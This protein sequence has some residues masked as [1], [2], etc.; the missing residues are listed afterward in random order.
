MKGFN[1]FKKIICA[2][3]L[4]ITILSLNLFNIMQSNPRLK[5]GLH[6]MAGDK[7]KFPLTAADVLVKSDLIVFAA[8]LNIPLG[9]SNISIINAKMSSAKPGDVITIENGIYSN[10]MI[11]AEAYGTEK[12]PITLKAE[13]PGGVIL[14][15]N[16]TISINGSY[17]VTDGF[18]FTEGWSARAITFEKNSSNCRLTNTA[19][20]DWNHSVPQTDTRWITIKGHNNRVDHCILRDKRNHGMM[21]EVIRDASAQYHLID[22]NY[23][24]FYADGIASNGA[25]T[26]RIGTSGESLSGSYTVLEYNVFES[27]NGEA[28]VVSNKSCHNIYRYN[29]F[30][31]CKGAL[32]LRHGFGCVVEGNVFIGGSK[33]NRC[34]GVRVIGRDHVVKNNYFYD[35]PNG[36]PAIQLEHGHIVPHVLTGYDQVERVIVDNNTFFQCDKNLIIGTGKNINSDPPRIMPPKGSVSNNLMVSNKGTG[37]LFSIEN[38]EAEIKLCHNV[39]GGKEVGLEPLPTGIAVKDNINMILASNGLYMPDDDMIVAGITDDVNI[40]KRTIL[41]VAP[42]WVINRIQLND[43]KFTD[44]PLAALP[45]AESVSTPW[46]SDDV[47]VLAV[48]N[49]DAYNKNI[50]IKIDPVSEN[51]VPIIVDGKTFMPVR[52]ISEL[53][54]SKVNWDNASNAVKIETSEGRAAKIVI[55]SKEIDINGTKIAMDVAAQLIEERTYLPLRAIVE[56]VLGKKVKWD[57]RGIILISNSQEVIDRFDDSALMKATANFM[58]V[59][60]DSDDGNVATNLVDNDLGTRWSAAGEG[61]WARFDLYEPTLVS[62]MDIATYS[63][64]KRKAIFDIQVSDDGI[65][66]DTVFSGQSSGTA[67]GFERYAFEPVL[68]RYVRLYGYGNSSN[69]WNS[70]SEIKIYDTNNN[71]VW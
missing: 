27:C 49:P 1:V 65:N 62:A 55:G 9:P 64:D 58:R 12:A 66:W 56:N 3:V 46:G 20:I 44:I 18:W 15:G 40:K 21:L 2:T 7:V 43:P 50:K 17:V 61:C 67:A 60:S 10:V 51:A 32:T 71:P 36:S 24:G 8:D 4:V 13:S 63:G 31:D 11:N 37:A 14:T 45:M 33:T 29:T 5:P 52:F 48:G 30:I 69:E 6:V 70:F 23:F 25:E 41:D 16:S 57:K 68:A 19:I 34:T 35:L 28:E 38:P 54:D 59:I 39:L 53:Y 42:Q 22:N 26:I 47:T